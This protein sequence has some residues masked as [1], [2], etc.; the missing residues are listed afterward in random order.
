[1]KYALVRSFGAE[2]RIMFYSRTLPGGKAEWLYSPPIRTF[3]SLD[4]A[5]VVRDALHDPA[6]LIVAISVPE[7][8]DGVIQ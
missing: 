1:M 7:Y 2:R 4:E 5:I 6:N 3:D 8:I